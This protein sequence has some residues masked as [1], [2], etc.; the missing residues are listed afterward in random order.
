MSDKKIGPMGSCLKCSAPLY[1]LGSYCNQKC[2][3]AITIAFTT[4]PD[5]VTISRECAERSHVRASYYL[6][7]AYNKA[8]GPEALKDFNELT[9][10]LEVTG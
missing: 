9:K 5:T 10:A 1:F 8:V 2:E 6:Q 7:A 4:K 3:D